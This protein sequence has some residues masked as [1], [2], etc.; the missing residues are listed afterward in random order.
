[1][2]ARDSSAELP[3]GGAQHTRQSKGGEGVSLGKQGD[4]GFPLFIRKV[5]WG[6][7]RERPEIGL[8]LFHGKAHVEGGSRDCSSSWLSL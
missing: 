7:L 8:D 6:G 4:A 2:T 3:K 5:M 1:M